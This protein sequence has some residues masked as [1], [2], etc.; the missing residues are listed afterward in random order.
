MKCDE[1][2]VEVRFLKYANN[3]MFLLDCSLIKGEMSLDR[4]GFRVSGFGFW[5]S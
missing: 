5:V 2:Q 4:F 3:R 1:R